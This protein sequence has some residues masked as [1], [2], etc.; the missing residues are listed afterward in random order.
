[1]AIEHAD[2]SG[3]QL[4]E[5]K[6]VETATAGEVYVADG[7]GSGNWT[8]H[9]ST[10]YNKNKYVLS[11][12]FDDLATAGSIY[13]HIPFKSKLIQVTVVPYGVIDANTD[14]NIYLDGVLF[15]D[16]FDLVAAGSGAGLKQSMT[17]VTNNSIDAGDIVR[18]E[19]DGAATASVRG[20]VQLVLEAI[21]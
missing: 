18:I 12:R 2:L 1:M 6:G 8:D 19:S 13:F 10:F 15:A 16:D 17:T 7:F 20:D 21:A 5:P 9:L 3:D 4:H 14:M 11:Q